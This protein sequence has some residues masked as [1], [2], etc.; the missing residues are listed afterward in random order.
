MDS[1]IQPLLDFYLQPTPTPEGMTSREIVTRSIE[2]R[3][4]PRVPY[5]FIA[6]VQSDFFEAAAIPLFIN[7]YGNAEAPVIFGDGRQQRDFVYV[8]DVVTANLAAV[9]REQAYGES[10]NIAGGA[11][12][13]IRSLLDLIAA[14]F[15]KGKEPE[16]MPAR[17]GDPTFSQAEIDK[18][19]KLLGYRPKV[20]LESGLEAT[21]QW[22]RSQMTI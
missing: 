6:P 15:P 21:V 18:A 16:L 19:E 1:P 12:V 9:T 20:G 14:S 11:S 2:F 17:P 4:P 13:T 5:S 7:A 8:E 22:F 3:D 10:I